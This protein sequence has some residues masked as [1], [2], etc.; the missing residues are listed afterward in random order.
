MYKLFYASILAAMFA[1]MLIK[2]K[3]KERHYDE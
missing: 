1:F 3:E 2:R